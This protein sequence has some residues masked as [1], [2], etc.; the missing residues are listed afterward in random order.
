MA[1][2]P[3]LVIPHQ[4]HHII[5]KGN[6]NKVIFVDRDDYAVFLGWLI[7]AS[8]QFEVAIHAYVLMPDHLHL[9]ATP[10]DETGLSRMMQWLG[11]HYVPYFNA[12]YHRS[13]TLW[14]GRYRA[15]VIQAAVYFLRCSL[16]IEA[17]PVLA[18]LVAEASDYSWSSYQHHIGLK[19]DPLITDH[20]LYWSLGN[21][22]FQRE[23]AYKEMMQQAQPSAE[24]EAMTAATLRGWLLGSDQFKAEMAKLTARRVEPVKRGRPSKQSK[25]V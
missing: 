11:R 1:R 3:R 25:L 15:T 12:K 14:Q 17:N 18:K 22:P 5:Q 23:A 6:D 4:L 24:I 19:I 21:T 2:L 10:S 8:K 20:P 7:Q 13:G 9:L 16:Y